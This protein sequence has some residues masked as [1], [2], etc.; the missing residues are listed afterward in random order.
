MLK[1]VGA[2]EWKT[3]IGSYILISTCI[4]CVLLVITVTI[5]RKE[6]SQTY[7]S[8]VFWSPK[9]GFSIKNWGQSNGDISKG[10][11]RACYKHS[12]FQNGWSFLEIETQ[13]DYPDRIQAFAAGMLE[14]SLTWKLIYDHWSNTI[15]SECNKND[16]S[17]KFCSWAKNILKRKYENSKT[18]S[19]IKER[20]SPYWYQIRLFY[21]QM[22]G[23]QHGWQLG[24]HESREDI[25]IPEED[26]RLLNAIS[27]W[28]DIQDYYMKFIDPA[29]NNRHRHKYANLFIKLLS[30]RKVLIGHSTDDL[31]SSML[32]M[33]KH[34]YFRFHI[35]SIT[36]SL[37][38]HGIN[39]SFTG[40]PGTIY[41]SDNYYIIQNKEEHFLIGGIRARVMAANR[42]AQSG[43]SWC[44]YMSHRSSTDVKQWMIV[45]INGFLKNKSN[46]IVEKE[47]KCSNVGFVYVAD[48][49]FGKLNYK[50]IT[51]YICKTEYWFSTRTSYID[52]SIKK[53][54]TNMSSQC[55][56]YNFVEFYQQNITTLQGL[57]TLLN[58]LGNKGVLNSEIYEFF[59]NVDMKLYSASLSGS[60]EY[61]S[62]ARPVQSLEFNNSTHQVNRKE[63]SA[64]LK[65]ICWSKFV[66][67]LY[68]G[69]PDIFEFDFVSPTWSWV[70]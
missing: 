7:C 54:N 13:A 2:N 62:N 52:G 59:G 49:V 40:Y 70:S 21:H 24:V 32:R 43:R 63:I 56:D 67:T 10:V 23:L 30:D 1:V 61:L 15:G 64:K 55:E 42:L 14:G 20:D 16:E 8:T 46:K 47:G 50:D 36:N 12:I 26:F 53:C 57:A 19:E 48:Q 25:N 60:I 35:S 58:C 69:Q 68:D 11:A 18:E 6:K 17:Q 29:Y 28:C 51:E 45:D 33:H 9:A 41:S 31:Y 5:E 37:S 44:K 27:D 66:P 39:I 22:A 4:L 38:V 34:Y 65:Q 3:R